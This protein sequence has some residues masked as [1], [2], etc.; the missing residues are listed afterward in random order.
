[1]SIL[2]VPHAEIQTRWYHVRN[3]NAKRDS[4]LVG[5]TY[6]KFPHAIVEAFKFEQ[7]NKGDDNL[8]GH[9]NCSTAKPLP[10]T[11]DYQWEIVKGNGNNL[12]DLCIISH[13]KTKREHR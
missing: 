2:E 8:H 3:I 5:R 10:L 6:G 7:S 11:Y 12:E 4:R 9:I 13:Y 1:M